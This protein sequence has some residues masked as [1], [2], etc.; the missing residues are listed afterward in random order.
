[1]YLPEQIITSSA[2]LG[3]INKRLQSSVLVITNS[4]I[5][6]K[7]LRLS[8]SLIEKYRNNTL[9]YTHTQNKTKTQ[10]IETRKINPSDDAL[11]REERSKRR[12]GGEEKEEEREGE[13]NES[14]CI[15]L[16]KQE[17]RE[18]G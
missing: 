10:N 18:I 12:N 4:D 1:M 5:R 7:K 9:Q 6:F 13:K 11:E 15:G 17:G 16:A 2:E 8:R 3:N 14:N